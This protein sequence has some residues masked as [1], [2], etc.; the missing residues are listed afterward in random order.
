VRDGDESDQW[1][2]SGGEILEGILVS[3]GFGVGVD[4][5]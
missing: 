2:V 5:V 4:D 1:A 3:V